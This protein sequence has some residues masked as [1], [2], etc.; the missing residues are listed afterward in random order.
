MISLPDSTYVATVVGVTPSDLL[1]ELAAGRTVLQIAG[2]RYT[3]ANDLATALLVPV[4]AKLDNGVASGRLTRE[5]ETRIYN[6]A[7]GV[8]EHLVVAPHPPLADDTARGSQPSGSKAAST[9]VATPGTDQQE[10]GTVLPDAYFV[11][12]VAG[13]TPAALQQDLAEGQTLL[14]IAGSKYASA[15]DLATALLVNL[16]TKLAYAASLG[17][18]SSEQENA[19]Y[20]QMHTAYVRLVTT[21][22]PSL[23][24]D[25]QAT[26]GQK[27]GGASS[28]VTP[29]T[30]S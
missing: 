7:H 30:C 3:S 23:S 19:I 8:Y 4:R 14:Q 25:E 13:V 29:Q 16:K 26:G 21:P 9:P 18:L 20:G 5:Q 27:L 17:K 24:T 2:N 15:S 22:H 10:G 1:H 12:S 11:A 28:A 6:Q